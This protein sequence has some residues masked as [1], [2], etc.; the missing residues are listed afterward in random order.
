[1]STIDP[2][3][4]VSG[5]DKTTGDILGG[6]N[7]ENPQFED[8]L[9]DFNQFLFFQ[10]EEGLDG[11]TM[12]ATDTLGEYL[13]KTQDGQEF[14][15]INTDEVDLDPEISIEMTEDDNANLVL[16]GTKAINVQGSDEDNKI[17]GNLGNNIIDGGQGDDLLGGGAG[18]DVLLGGEG[19]DELMGGEGNDQLKGGEGGDKFAYPR[20]IPPSE[21]EG[22]ESY[23]YGNDVISDFGLG[24][25]TLLLGDFNGDGVFDSKDYTIENTEGGAL[26]TFIGADGSRGSVLLQGVDANQLNFNV[27]A[28]GDIGQV[29]LSGNTAPTIA[30]LEPLD[31]DE[32][33]FTIM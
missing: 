20:D 10:N 16:G 33:F 13:L 8:Q 9:L 28:E 18:D 22:P 19:N 32:T 15:V 25:D 29:T 5:S 14:K 4:G 12:E 27:N 2:N 11:S 17:M 1:M 26:V 3:Q 7:P 31:D 6:E 30:D 24:D 23:S 21:E